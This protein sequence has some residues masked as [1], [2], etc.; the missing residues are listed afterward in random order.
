MIRFIVLAY[1]LAMAP[2]PTYAQPAGEPYY[3]D[4]EEVVFVFDIRVYA[5]ALLGENA[6]KV[7]FAD[8]GIYDVA[9]TGDF[10]NW[11]NK[12]WRM[13]KRDEFIFELR[14]NIQGFNDAFPF[15]FRYIINGRYIADPEGQ[16]TDPRQFQDNFLED[17]YKVDFNVI[18]IVEKGNV[19]FYLEG[20][21]N[22]GEVILAGTFNGW[23][24]QE[25]KMNKTT[26]GWELHANLPSGRY[27]YKFIVDGEWMHDPAN[28]QTVRNEHHTL[29]S[30]LDITL[31]VTFILEGFQDAKKVILAGSFNDWHEKK[32]EMIR[33]DG[34]W[35]A[36]LHLPAGK[37]T[38]KFI[39][40]GQWMTDPGN[41][42]IEDDG[43]GNQNSVKFVH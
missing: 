22:A 17:V 18:D 28:N 31:P 14:K 19:V 6:L 16:I 24:E 33:K 30:V 7:D 20:Y 38:Y 27:E 23:H 26:D 35:E 40:D 39:V 37:H 8:M 32:Q 29:N 1:T 25:L 21:P 11:S 2:I 36:V 3:F 41:P 13:H 12:G 42:I 4:G 15:D 9:L 10:N 5:K 43:F 34:Y